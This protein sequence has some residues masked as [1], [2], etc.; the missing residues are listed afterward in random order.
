MNQEF[1]NHLVRSHG[2]KGAEQILADSNSTMNEAKIFVNE[3]VNA[4]IGSEKN[5]INQTKNTLS[6]DYKDVKTNIDD[7]VFKQ[8]GEPVKNT[9]DKLVKD[10]KDGF[11]WLDKKVPRSN[12]DFDKHAK[13]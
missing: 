9:K 6:Q 4:M 5:I 13:K 8:I 11:K 1:V 7:D 2:D 12:D 10:V 3:K